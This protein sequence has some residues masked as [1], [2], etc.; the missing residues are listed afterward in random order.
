MANSK[1]L[2]IL[3]Q[4]VQAWN[5]WRCPNPDKPLD[6]RDADLSFADLSGVHLPHVNFSNVDLKNTNLWKANL[7]RADLRGANLSGAHLS[8]GQFIRSD[9]SRAHLSGANLTG[10]DL[11]GS[12]L[13]HADLTNALL[14]GSDLRNADLRDANLAHAKMSLS[15][16]IHTNLNKANITQAMFR[17][18]VI[19]DIDLRNVIGL[20]KVQHSGPSYI[21]IDT[22]FRSN[23]QIPRDFLLGCGLSDLQI[24]TVMGAEK[25]NRC[26]ISHDHR[27]EAFAIKIQNDLR[28][29]GVPCWFARE[30]MGVGDPIRETIDINI[31]SC[32]KL[33]VI[34]SKNSV[35]SEWVG[36]EV[37]VALEA[38]KER[39]TM[40]FPIRL[41]DAVDGI[42]VGW[43]A[44]I[45]RERNIGDFS[46]WHDPL[47]Y[48]QAFDRILRDLAK[49]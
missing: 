31:W 37:E 48:Q 43:A 18:V 32:E 3:E 11:S 45:R 19:G 42:K 34:L 17:N 1:H 49:K 40:V 47:D 14:I 39:G 33:L 46:K 29:S 4:G 9:F 44:K 25:S 23:G 35:D 5:D 7:L 26:F 36:H 15:I 24:K 2:D 8:F 30:D 27:D 10:A 28:K 13:S 16:L 6:L 38:E 12:I 41:D 20:D 21:S 22:I